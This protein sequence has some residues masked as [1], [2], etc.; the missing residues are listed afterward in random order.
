MRC[1][2]HREMRDG[3]ADGPAKQMSRRRNEQAGLNTSLPSEPRVARAIAARLPGDHPRTVAVRDHLQNAVIGFLRSGHADPQFLSA[4]CDTREHE[5]WSRLSEALVAQRLE[6]K[7]FEKAKSPGEGPDLL[8]RHEG[9]RIWIEVVCPEPVDV[10]AEWLDPQPLLGHSLPQSELLL[11]WT[12]AIYA[13]ANRLC[14]T[15]GKGKGYLERGIVR[16]DDA[17]VIAVN[18]CRL[19]SGPFSSLIGISQFPFAAEAVFPIGPYQ[20]RIDPDSHEIV[21][22]GHQLRPHV[23]KPNGADVPTQMFLDAENRAVSAI[24]AVD[25]NGGVACGNHEPSFVVHNPMASNPVPVGFL[26]A[27][28]DYVATRDGDDY[29]LRKIDRQ[30]PSG[31]ARDAG[32]DQNRNA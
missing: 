26:P 28:A 7:V 30:P 20:V 15:R 1:A 6:G 8:L 16:A 27:D 21:D 29:E 3:D 31:G 5:F 12:T 24:W 14:C 22:R 4:F 10:P 9:R 2:Y 17:Y 32:Q 25:F 11:R 13:K 23:S 19:R 18:A